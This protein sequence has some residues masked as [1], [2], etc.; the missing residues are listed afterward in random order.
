MDS[1]KRRRVAFVILLFL[2]ATAWGASLIWLAAGLL[3]QDS[4]SWLDALALHFLALSYVTIYQLG[5]R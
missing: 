2:A 5:E 1:E 4:I 3:D